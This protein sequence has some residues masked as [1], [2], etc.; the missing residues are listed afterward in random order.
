[1]TGHMISAEFGAEAFS[2]SQGQ[3]WLMDAG[4]TS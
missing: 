3:K 1:M 2:A 4:N